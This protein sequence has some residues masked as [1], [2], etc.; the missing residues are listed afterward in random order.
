MTNKPYRTPK[1]MGL[2]AT[3]LALT[4]ALA[5]STVAM[6]GEAPVKEILN[7]RFGW[8]V[9]KTTKGNTCTVASKD[10]CQFATQNEGA[11]GFDIA[12]GGCGG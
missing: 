11:G 5:T 1:T 8:D 3:A 9:N 6:A 7:S 10:E 12:G 2:L 4:L